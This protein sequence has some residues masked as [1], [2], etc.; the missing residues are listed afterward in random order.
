MERERCL[1]QGAWHLFPRVLQLP[2]GKD[3]LIVPACYHKRIFL[4]I[5]VLALGVYP[6][7]L[8]DLMEP[9]IAQL[10]MQLA[11]SKL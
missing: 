6:K 11:N 5:C 3:A 7:P 8:T 9:S 2:Q 4:A 1:L 10:A